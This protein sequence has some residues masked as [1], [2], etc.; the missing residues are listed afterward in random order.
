MSGNSANQFGRR[1]LKD[2][3]YSLGIACAI[4]EVDGRDGGSFHA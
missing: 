2:F 3:S 4:Y 1:L